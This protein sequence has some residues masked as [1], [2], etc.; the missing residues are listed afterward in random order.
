V[1]KNGEGGVLVDTSV[2][3]LAVVSINSFTGSLSQ[4]LML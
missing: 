3:M 2:E 1:E 4:G